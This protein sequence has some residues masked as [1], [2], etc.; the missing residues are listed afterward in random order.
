MEEVRAPTAV[1]P[2]QLLAQLS[3]SPCGLEVA[4][5][6][7]GGVMAPAVRET[8]LVR[9]AMVGPLVAVCWTLWRPRVGV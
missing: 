7:L 4:A 8:V 9:R 2:P 3:D 6:E 5:G 1:R